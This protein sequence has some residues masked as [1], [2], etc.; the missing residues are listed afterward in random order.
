MVARVGGQLRQVYSHTYG[1]GELLPLASIMDVRMLESGLIY[2]LAMNEEGQV[3]LY[4][5]EPL[6]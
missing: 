2:F 4:V 5:A 6:F 1:I 3:G